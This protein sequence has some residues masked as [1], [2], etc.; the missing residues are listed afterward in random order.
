MKGMLCPRCLHCGKCNTI[1]DFFNQSKIQ[2]FIGF[3]ASGCVDRKVLPL[4]SLYGPLLNDNVPAEMLI[5]S[6]TGI[7]ISFYTPPD[8]EHQSNTHFPINT[9]IVTPPKERSAD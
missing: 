1:V 5:D 7:D 2:P 9:V 4:K 6:P 8:L 3:Y